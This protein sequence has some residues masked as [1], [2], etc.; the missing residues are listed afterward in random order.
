MWGT[1]AFKGDGFIFSLI[2]LVLAAVCL[3]VSLLFAFK[4]ASAKAFTFNSIAIAMAVA[5][6]FAMLFPNVMKSSIDPAYS[7]TIAQS[8]ASAGTQIVMTVAAIILVPIVLGYTIWSVYM[9]RA[10]ISVAPAGGLEPDKI[11][12]GANFLVG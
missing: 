3:I 7:L 1:F 5:W 6:V 9:F 12:E 10:R 2:F 8:A 4:G 11:R